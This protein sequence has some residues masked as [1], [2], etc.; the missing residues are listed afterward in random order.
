M[1]RNYFKIAWRNLI[2]NKSF[3]FINLLGLATGFAIALLIIQY[4]RFELSYE[5]EHIN[6]EQLVR[7]TTD[8]MDGET[9]AAQDCE[10]NPPLGLR[11]YDELSEVINY[12]RAYPV[13]EPS[14]NITI[15]ER[16]FV[17]EKLYAVDSSFFS[18]FTYPLI[19]GTT[20]NIFIQ[21]NEAVISKKI[22]LTYFNKTNVIGETIEMPASNGS[23]LLNVVGVANDP[24]PN[25]HLKF[26]MLIS[27]PTML[28]DPILF[29][30][31]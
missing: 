12:T 24:S 14:V 11:I 7:L 27:Y 26:D 1:I 19:H 28:K 4:A 21:P 16:N 5:N 22:A 2:K 31:F 10:T 20:K 13:G 23:I 18:M 3:T 30:L 25:T 29:L 15:G 8:Y 17:L 9:V 6:K